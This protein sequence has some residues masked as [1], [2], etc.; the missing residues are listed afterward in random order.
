MAVDALT[1]L[2][3]NNEDIIHTQLADEILALHIKTGKV[4][5]WNEAALNVWDL[6]VTPQSA[7]SL[8]Q[9]LYPTV[10]ALPETEQ[11]LLAW[12]NEAADKDFLYHL[13]PSFEPIE[14]PAYSPQTTTSLPLMDGK[15][16]GMLP[17]FITSFSLSSSMIQGSSDNFQTDNFQTGS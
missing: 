11:A 7:H 10:A 12:L 1:Y 4:Y 15:N 17:C 3:R 8:M 13:P 16:A 2:K 14:S 6:L 9:L 5:Q